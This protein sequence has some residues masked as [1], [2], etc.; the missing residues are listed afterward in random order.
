MEEK[1]IPSKEYIEGFLDGCFWFYRGIT[2][3]L[4]DNDDTKEIREMLDLEMSFAQ[5]QMDEH[6]YQHI[7][8]YL[9]LSDKPD[10][11]ILEK[12]LYSP[13]K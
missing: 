7:E 12:V 8:K 1:P 9:G 2:G 13:S 3:E 5:K 10:W 4:A 6:R 11:E